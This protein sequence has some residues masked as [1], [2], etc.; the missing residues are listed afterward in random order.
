ML[1][2]GGRL[3]RRLT[4]LLLMSS[5]RSRRVQI[6]HRD[7]IIVMVVCCL[8]MILLLYAAA[9][10]FLMSLLCCV[11]GHHCVAL[12]TSLSFNRCCRLCIVR[13]VLLAG[14]ARENVLLLG[15]V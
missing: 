8:L 6:D 5:H 12:R 3:S 1:G 2:C 4:H 11:S 10:P 7:E 15:D 13:D 14:L 9:C